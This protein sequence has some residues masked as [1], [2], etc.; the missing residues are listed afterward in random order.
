[1]WDINSCLAAGICGGWVLALGRPLT[2][3][4]VVPRRSIPTIVAI[5]RPSPQTPHGWHLIAI[6]LQR[7]HQYSLLC[8]QESCS[9][10][11]YLSIKMVSDDLFMLFYFLFATCEFVQPLSTFFPFSVDAP[12]GRGSFPVLT[13]LHPS[14]DLRTISQVWMQLFLLHSAL[15]NQMWKFL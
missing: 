14:T 4:S 7:V 9:M 2:L 3:V 1:M 11:L 10:L 15:I 6:D 8:H 13:H 12:L 5:P